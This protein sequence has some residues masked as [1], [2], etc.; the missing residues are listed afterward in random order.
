MQAFDI[1]CI[2]VI[3][4][5]SAGKSSFVQALTG[6]PLPRA[7]GR[8]TTRPLEIQIRRP[9]PSTAEATDPQFESKL[10][11]GDSD[12]DMYAQVT[13]K[14]VPRNEQETAAAAHDYGVVDDKT[15][16]ARLEDVIK[17]LNNSDTSYSMLPIIVQVTMPKH[18]AL[19]IIDLPGLVM[20]A[21]TAS[22]TRSTNP[23]S[24]T[25]TP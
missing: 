22:C 7:T 2:V 18:I 19:T 4:D 14:A 23:S 6:V 3:G 13:V 20:K 24:T 9:D 1:P 11:A 5:Q 12:D 17:L 25:A 16:L 21:Q 10:H 8:C 15:A